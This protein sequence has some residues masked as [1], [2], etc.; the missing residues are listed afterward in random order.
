MS[1]LPPVVLRYEGIDVVRDDMLEGGSKS[2]FS[3]FLIEGAREVVYGGPCA[4]GALLALSVIGRRLSIKVTLFYAA[5]RPR[6]WHKNQ[7]AAKANG[8]TIYLV[9]TGYMT[10]VQAKAQA[11]AAARSALFLPLGFNVPQASEPFIDAMRQVRRRLDLPDE[12][13]CA[14]GSGMLARCLGVAFPDSEVLGVSVGLAS[15]HDKQKFTENVRLI[16]SGY[17]FAAPAKSRPLFPSSAEYDAKAWELCVRMLKGRPLFW[18][19]L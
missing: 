14:T 3:P 17:A 1:G 7:R 12:I 10:H 15:R 19:V 9:P 18:N 5:R 4:G 16:E 2:R 11:Y 13:W 8:A 6:N